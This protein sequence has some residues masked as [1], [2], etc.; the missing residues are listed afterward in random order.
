MREV[1]GEDLQTVEGGSSLL[2]ALVIILT[3]DQQRAVGSAQQP[4]LI[5]EPTHQ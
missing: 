2:R 1:I 5:H 4:T 3:A